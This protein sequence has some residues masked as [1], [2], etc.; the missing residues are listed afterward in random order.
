MQEKG[1]ISDISV[2]NFVIEN[3][4]IVLKLEIIADIE[5]IFHQIQSMIDRYP[6]SIGYWDDIEQERPEIKQYRLLTAFWSHIQSQYSSRY[7]AFGVATGHSKKTRSRRLGCYYSTLFTLMT[8]P[9]WLKKIPKRHEFIAPLRNWW[10]RVFPV[11]LGGTLILKAFEKTSMLRRTVLLTKWTR[12]SKNMASTRTKK[13]RK[14]KVP[15]FQYWSLR[16]YRP[17]HVIH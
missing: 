6:R 8:S 12:L 3:K 4:D 2:A 11:V 7:H 10:T 15:Q 9:V 5:K 1:E 17:T 16:T 13:V 14:L